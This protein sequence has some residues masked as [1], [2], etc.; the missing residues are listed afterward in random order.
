YSVGLSPSDTAAALAA[1]RLL[2][3]EP[4]RVRRLQEN[5]ELFLK[6]AQAQGL[7]TGLSRYSAVVPVIVGDSFAALKCS[8]RLFERSINVLPLVHPAVDTDAARLRFFLNCMHTE[9]QIH[10]TIEAL[11][12][13]LE[14][15]RQH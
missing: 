12:E 2:K 11:V 5:S 10:T 6:A 8:Q 4:E 1:L 14:H 13:E 15:L 3:A 9:E 7:D